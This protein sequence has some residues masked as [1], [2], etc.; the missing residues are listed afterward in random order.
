MKRNKDSTEYKESN[1]WWQNVGS[2]KIGA[3]FLVNVFLQQ[4][5]ENY[6]EKRRDDW[7]ML[8][9]ICDDTWN[10]DI[11]NVFNMQHIIQN[12]ERLFRHSWWCYLKILNGPHTRSKVATTKEID[13]TVSSG[14]TVFTI[15]YVYKLTDPKKFPCLY[16]P[17]PVMGAYEHVPTLATIKEKSNSWKP[18][19][20]KGKGLK[21]LHGQ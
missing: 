12:L 15:A 5:L 18:P 19:S 13:C 4:G 17:S 11:W 16:L 9:T 3:V 2:E 1:L 20:W 8:A 6:W 10:D 14:I 21:A 7:L